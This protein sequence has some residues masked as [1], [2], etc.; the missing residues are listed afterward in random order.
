MNFLKLFLLFTAVFFR[1]QDGFEITENKKTTVIP[2]QLINNLIFIPVELNGVP[3]TFLL[4]TGVAETILFSTDNK[5]INFKNIEKIKFSGLGGSLEIEG[6]KS[7]RNQLK[8]GKN[9]T[10]SS[11]TIFI[12]LDEDFNF[13]SHIG[14][15]VNGIIGYYFFRNHPV[16]INYI[17]KKITV[18]E[19]EKA[20]P[21]NI[22]KFQQLPITV[23]Y[24]KPYVVADVEMKNEKNSSKL[25]LDLGNSDAL[26]LF[27]ALIKD[28]VYN[29]PNI[30]DFLGRGFNGDVYGKRSRIHH[31]YLGNFKFEKPLMAMPDEFSI[32]HV[33][34][35]KDRK[36]SVG[37]EI[38]RRFNI[39]FDYE[40]KKMYLRKNKNYGDDFHFN[41]SG[42]DFKHD[43]VKWEEEMVKVETPT[44]NDNAG[45]EVNVIANPFQYKFVL[46]PIY[47]VAGI[48]KDSPAFKA[49]LMKGDQILSINGKKTSSMSLNQINDLMKS[50]EGKFIE[51]KA[52]RN[53]LT[54]TF[55]FNLEDPIP[56]R[57]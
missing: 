49:G 24:N 28:F 1:A 38:L 48:R 16:S 47:S 33:N 5:E 29:R 19:D 50:E 55:S 20:L 7:I 57:E 39:I 15:P 41:M 52:T 44:K 43:G 22:G 42:I 11:H 37:S 51:I 53:T 13:S 40:N 26:W 54:L 30:E 18:F 23:E 45:N 8:I 9:F 14:I 27:P 56:Y 6:L 10:D 12:I 34:L 17:T 25:L 3:L 21:K 32:Q 2:F 36:G 35:V 4:D 31:F 46:K